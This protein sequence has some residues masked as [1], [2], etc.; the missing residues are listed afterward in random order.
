MFKFSLQTALNVRSRQEKLKMKALAEKLAVEQGIQSQIEQ[1]LQNTKESES[2]LNHAKESRIFSVDQMLFLSRFKNKMKVDLSKCHE[3]LEGAKKEVWD[4]QQDLIE[5][6][7]KKKTLEILK[8]KEEKRYLE[9]I[10]NIER[11]SMDEIAGNQFVQKT[12]NAESL[13]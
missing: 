8:E 10:A 3:E 5:A 1:I 12:R 6:S 7:K 11:R 9:N 2:N 4:K 13:S